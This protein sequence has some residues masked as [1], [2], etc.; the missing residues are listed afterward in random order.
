M[1]LTGEPVELL[2]YVSGRR[3][4]AL[5]ETSGAPDAVAEFDRWVASI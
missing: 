3:D 1:V 5:V 2:L 4:A